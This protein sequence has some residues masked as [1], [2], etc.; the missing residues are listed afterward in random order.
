[1]RGRRPRRARRRGGQHLRPLGGRG[2]GRRRRW[3][4][5]RTSTP[6]PTPGA[7]TG[8]SACSA[9]WRRSGRCA[10]PASARARS[11]E[12]IM[13]TAEE[14]TRF[15]FGCLGSRVLAG[16]VDDERLARLRDADG[17]TL[18]EARAGGGRL[19]RGGRGPPGA[20]RTTPPSSSCTSS[21][22]PSWSATACPIGVVTAIAAP[23]TLRVEL[24]G[25]GGHAGRGA[26]GRSATT[27]SWRRRRW[28]WRS[29]RRP[30]VA[31]G[32]T[33]TVGTVGA[34]DGRARARSTA[35]R[36]RVRMD[37]DIRDTDLARRDAVLDAGARRARGEPPR[38]ARRGPRRTRS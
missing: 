15:A 19:R 2:P 23:A 25:E 20:G 7:S 24:T 31:R 28:C 5:A 14:P 12:L 22:G 4:P 33:D 1:M 21:R 16:V 9:A 32:A 38:R 3:R 17:G 13:F 18:D 6:S 10:P 29:N 34:A 30:R 11:I 26:D 8:W 37:I 27:R 36:G 35:S